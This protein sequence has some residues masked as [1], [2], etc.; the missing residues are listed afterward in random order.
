MEQLRP[1]LEFTLT[2]VLLIA[3]NTPG[4]DIPGVTCVINMSMPH[5]LKQYIHR[6]G[7]TARAG[8]EGRSVTL[9]G[10]MERKILRQIVKAGE[11]MLKSRVVAPKVTTMPFTSFINTTTETTVLPCLHCAPCS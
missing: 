10:E 5:T 2:C 9:V 3:C 8:T 4:I 7:R 11:G 6:V 1:L